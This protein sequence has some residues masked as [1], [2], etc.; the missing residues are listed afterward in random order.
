MSYFPQPAGLRICYI[1][2]KPSIFKSIFKAAKSDKPFI[3]SETR[4]K[5][6]SES[7]KTNYAKSCFL[8]Y[9]PCKNIDLGAPNVQVPIQKMNKPWVIHEP[10]KDWF[11][12]YTYHSLNCASGCYWSRD[13]KMLKSKVL[14]LI[15]SISEAVA[16]NCVNPS[17]RNSFL[18]SWSR[19]Q[20]SKNQI[21]I[22]GCHIVDFQSRGQQIFESKLVELI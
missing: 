3:P 2:K 17:P 11:R 8:H 21:R 9:L 19:G 15:S 1:T 14:E 7:I 12:L 10:G 13:Q 4:Q 16:R 18:D 6:K 22:P 5:D 20:N